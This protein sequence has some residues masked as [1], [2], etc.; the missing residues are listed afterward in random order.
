[1]KFS[2]VV[3]EP[4]CAMNII[5]ILAADISIHSVGKLWKKKKKRISVEQMEIESIVFASVSRG[6]Q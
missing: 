2:W 4:T 6:F 1:M 5:G 3:R